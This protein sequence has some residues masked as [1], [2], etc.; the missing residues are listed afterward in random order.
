M[1]LRYIWALWDWLGIVS[2]KDLWIPCWP[3]HTISIYFHVIVI[4]I[5]LLTLILLLL[6]VLNE[7]MLFW[8]WVR[9]G[10]KKS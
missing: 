9:I 1:I 8:L 7:M 4:V 10:T 6:N 2:H 3:F 5:C